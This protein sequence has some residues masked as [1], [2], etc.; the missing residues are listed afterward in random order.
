MRTIR[1]ASLPNKESSLHWAF[2]ANSVTIFGPSPRHLGGR[3]LAGEINELVLPYVRCLWASRPRRP[4]ASGRIEVVKKVCGNNDSNDSLLRTIKISIIIKTI[5]TI[6]CESAYFDFSQKCTQKGYFRW[7]RLI[8]VKNWD[9]KR[10]NQFM[11]CKNW[12]F[13]T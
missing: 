11:L 1:P 2:V 8:W 5:K 3:E 4:V 10:W 13:L 9:F 6:N 12:S 7:K